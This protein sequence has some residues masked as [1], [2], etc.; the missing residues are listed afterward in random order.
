MQVAGVRGEQ[1]DLAASGLYSEHRLVG[2]GRANC[3]ARVL[4]LW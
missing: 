4:P 1:L 3:I 2:I